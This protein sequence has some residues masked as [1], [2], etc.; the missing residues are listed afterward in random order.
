MNFLTKNPA[1][2]M[3][4]TL[5]LGL[6]L[7]YYQHKTSPIMLSMRMLNVE[8]HH[9]PEEHPVDLGMTH[10]VPPE[11]LKAGTVEKPTH[12]TRS[13]LTPLSSRSSTR[14]SAEA[15]RTEVNQEAIKDVSII[16]DR[17]LW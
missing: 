5:R 11:M 9:G 15:T 2:G 8:P 14:A 16:F 13:G 1:G 6:D 3:M 7:L 17:T 4:A 12:V 10:L